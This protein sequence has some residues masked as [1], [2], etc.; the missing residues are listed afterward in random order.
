MQNV[1][2][3][4]SNPTKAQTMLCKPM[5][6]QHFMLCNGH[7]LWLFVGRHLENNQLKDLPEDIF[8]NNTKLSSLWVALFIQLYITIFKFFI[9]QSEELPTVPISRDIKSLTWYGFDIMLIW[10]N[11]GI[12]TTYWQLFIILRRHGSFV[13]SHHG[14]FGSTASRQYTN[15]GSTKSAAMPLRAV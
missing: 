8:R 5:G 15:H 12:E 2:W 4:L 3:A 1:L 7:W 10:P 14:Y 6:Y 13:W 9:S 11:L